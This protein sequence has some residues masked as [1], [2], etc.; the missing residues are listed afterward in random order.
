MTDKSAQRGLLVYLSVFGLL[1]VALQVGACSSTSDEP[2]ETHE[3]QWSW[4]WDTQEG[5]STGT[6][7]LGG[8]IPDLIRLSPGVLAAVDQQNSRV[9][10]F[11]TDGAN[12][13][14]IGKRGRGP[15]EF[16]E[17]FEISVG[18]DDHTIWVSDV[19]KGGLAKYRYAKG[20]SE[21]LVAH[22]NS[23]VGQ[24]RWYPSFSVH[25]DSTYWANRLRFA[26]TLDNS[27]HRIQLYHVN[28]E[29]LRSFGEMDDPEWAENNGH[30]R[31]WNFG[32]VIDL[33]SD[34]VAF[35]SHMRPLLEL[36]DSSG[37][38]LATHGVEDPRLRRDEPGEFEPGRFRFPIYFEDACWLP[39]R[40][41]IYTLSAILPDRGWLILGFD[42]DDLELK[43]QYKFTHPT[44]DSLRF[45]IARIAADQEGDSV[46]FYATEVFSSNIVVLQAKAHRKGG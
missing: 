11:D 14:V 16:I 40:E 27:G 20:G 32:E 19:L 18:P 45:W 36:W 26:E 10:V 31:R 29:L 21:F 12:L 24:N 46:V 42:A 33:T 35:V 6:Y 44:P 17:P 39:G 41:R 22:Q 7:L 8:R 5:E 9:V 1:L 28:G 38:L 23:W 3:L 34:R 25:T 43:E 30:L 2:P 15:G 13:D 4:L 37:E